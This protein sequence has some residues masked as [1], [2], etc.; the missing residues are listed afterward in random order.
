[1]SKLARDRRRTGAPAPLKAGDVLCGKYRVERLLGEGGMGMV[2]AAQHLM[3][4]HAVA[5]K[6]LY[7]D[8][9]EAVGRLLAEARSASRLGG[10]HVARVIDVDIG[11][12]GLPFIVMEYLEGIDLNQV[13]AQKGQL[14]RWQVVD[15]TLQALEGISQAHARGIVHRD[16]KPSNLFVARLADGKEVLKILDFG[17]SKSLDFSVAQQS[18]TGAGS[19]LGSPPYMSPEQVRSPKTV[20][21]RTD[22]WSIGVVMYELLTGK[23]PFFGT[24]IQETFAQIL[25]RDVPSIRA[26]VAGVPDGLEKVILRCLA[27]DRDRRFQDV[28]ELARELTPF[29]SGAWVK[30]QDR[31]ASILAR[32]DEPVSA[33]SSNR[34]LLGAGLTSGVISTPRPIS[35]RPGSPPPGGPSKH[36]SLAPDFSPTAAT[37]IGKKAFVPA[38]PRPRVWLAVVGGVAAAVAILGAGLLVRSRMQQR[39]EVDD[40][41][42]ASPPP[43]VTADPVAVTPPST[44]ATVAT[45]VQTGVPMAPASI[46]TGIVEASGP[47][48]ARSSAPAATS[49]GRPRASVAPASKPAP[50]PTTPAGPTRVELDP[51]LH[52][53]R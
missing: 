43:A 48:P 17:V 28:A 15:Y 41:S 12:N 23:L 44:V 52:G 2:V 10:E 51:V 7:A 45:P 38:E 40:T 24:E 27:K 6:L 4:D 16:L 31:I 49:P 50:P 30:S 26:Q 1:V 14:P 25:E 5:I 37:V 47:S 34:V 39:E 33:V 18:Y 9:E 11:E 35:V 53:R 20:D 21:L 13:L 22:I 19:V 36:D 8:D 3:L 46:S 29:G 42:A 32:G